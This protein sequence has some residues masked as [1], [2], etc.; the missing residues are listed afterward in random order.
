[1]FIVLEGID[2]CGKST[3]AR[4]LIE[5]LRRRGSETLHLHEPGGTPLGDTIR[6]IV[7]ERDG[8][9]IHA[10]AEALLYSA[11]R[12]E[13]VRSVLKPALSEGKHVL[14]E[15]FY[16]STLAYQGYGLGQDTG[17]LQAISAYA[18]GAL[19]PQRVVLLDIDPKEALLRVGRHLDR[20]EV[21]G[22][23]YLQRVREGYL[24][25]AR[26]EPERF[27]VVA[28]AGGIE[29]VQKRIVEALHDVLP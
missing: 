7:L 16:Y 13:L 12:A 21:R 23:E 28:A 25:L 9:E 11:A 19:R 6:Q 2:G 18:I 4:L 24:L 27:R 8:V 5:E 29:V 17:A 3:Q 10:S 22:V 20:I 26:R 14:C 1:M 15:R